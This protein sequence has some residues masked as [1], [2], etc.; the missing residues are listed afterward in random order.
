M[1]WRPP[2]GAATIEQTFPTEPGRDYLFSGWL[3]HNW[4][5]GEGRA[6]VS[7]NGA[8]F[9]QLYHNIPGTA[10]DMH[11]TP[12][13]YRF[14]TTAAAT[15]LTLEDVTG[16]DNAHGT[17]LDGLS[18]TLAG[19]QHPPIISAADL[20]APTNLTGRFVPGQGVQLFWQDNSAD[21]NAFVVWRKTPTGDWTRV[22]VLAPN[23]TTFLDQSVAQ[24][25]SYT[26]RVRATRGYTA[27]AW[28][29]EAS[30]TTP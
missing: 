18:V 11:W 14:R 24:G 25:M 22:G 17:A 5:I 16:V 15:T 10:Q 29:N 1:L 21:E 13:S 20:P 6:N 9:V 30:V 23:T 7:L 3:S 28:S 8:F 2:S 26:Y 19:D 12:F 4:M 27:S